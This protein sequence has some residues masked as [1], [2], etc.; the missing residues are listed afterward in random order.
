MVH[1][2][3]GFYSNGD[4]VVNMVDDKDLAD[5]IRYNSTFRPGRFYYVDG[6]YVCG[7]MLIL[8]AKKERIAQHEAQIADMKLKPTFHAITPYH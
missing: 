4:Y 1:V 5:N 2:C 7:G 3:V 8:E 6:K